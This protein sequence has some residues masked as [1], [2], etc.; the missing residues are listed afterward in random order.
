VP[1]GRGGSRLRAD[2][3]A[4]VKIHVD[5]FSGI[6]GF[7]LGLERAGFKTVVFCEQ[8]KFCQK[9]LNKHWPEIRRRNFVMGSGSYELGRIKK[10]RK[11]SL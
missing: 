2:G 7:S 6:G 11:R 1:L 5:L 9:V 8:D 3:G 4:G 10:Q